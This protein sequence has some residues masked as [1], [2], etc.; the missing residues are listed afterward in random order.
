MEVEQEGHEHR[1][2]GDGNSVSGYICINKDKSLREVL[3]KI[4]GGP[5]Y[6][7]MSR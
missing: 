1:A 3:Q 5:A 6:E 2:C 4:A 7:V